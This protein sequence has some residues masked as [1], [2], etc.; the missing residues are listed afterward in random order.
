M[1]DREMEI[2]KIVG[3]KD[4]EYREQE[5]GVLQIVDKKDSENRQFNWRI[6]GAASAVV[7]GVLGISASIL[8]GNV[9]FKPPHD[10]HKS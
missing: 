7:I 6:I 5:T 10:F 8:G 4:S 9:N 1:L 3:E 2:L